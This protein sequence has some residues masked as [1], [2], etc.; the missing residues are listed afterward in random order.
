MICSPRGLSSSRRHNNSIELEVKT[1][2]CAFWAP[3]ASE[4]VSR[5]TVLAGIIDPDYQREIGL[6]LCI[7]GKE[8]HV[9]NTGDALEYLLVW[10][11]W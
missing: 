1:A 4:S 9:C 7:T 5:V 11:V 6:L 2:I 10:Y 8:E 3:H